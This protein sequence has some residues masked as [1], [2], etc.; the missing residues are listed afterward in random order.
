MTAVDFA[1]ERRWK[2]AAGRVTAVVVWARGRR[3]QEAAP[4][5]PAQSVLSGLCCSVGSVP[6]TM[7]SVSS[8]VCG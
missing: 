8:L 3:R 7:G 4:G 2:V 6:S 1:G 5:K